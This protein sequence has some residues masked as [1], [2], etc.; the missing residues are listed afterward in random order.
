MSFKSWIAY[1]S[2]EAIFHI[3][4]AAARLLSP[5]LFRR[6]SAPLFQLLI[7]A[8]LPRRRIFRNLTAAFGE[9]YSPAT[10]KGLA[11]GVQEHFAKNLTD[12]FLQLADPGHARATITVEGLERLDA[13]L[14]RGKGVIALGAHI[15]NFVLVGTRLGS[16]G[17]PFSTLF[18]LPSDNRIKDTIA[19][20]LSSVIYHQ[21]I[22]PS[23]PRRIAVRRVLQ[24]LKQNEIVFILGDNLKRGK[25]DTFFFGQRVPSPRGPVSLALR[26][27]A[28]LV[29]MYMIRNYQGELHLVI[30]PGVLLIRNGNI[31]EDVS[32]NTRRIVEYLEKLI[33]R[34]PDQWNWLT[35][36][37]KRH[38]RFS[39]PIGDGG[40]PSPLGEASFSEM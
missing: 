38:R 17:Y 31:Y 32:A 8:A 10:R 21:R 26:S 16:E 36:R 6:L 22:I 1:R 14:G 27:G 12:C 35:V 29:P 18:R 19:R 39:V 7:Y 34:Y 3:L 20:H 37:M 30:E 15:G 5:R 33:A 23:Q 24:A 25:V 4:A 13:A 2:I 40:N 11:K 9:T 28:A